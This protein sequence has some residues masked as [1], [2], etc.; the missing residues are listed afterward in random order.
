MEKDFVITDE[1][2]NDIK[3]SY[4]KHLSKII[5]DE[6]LIYDKHL[7]ISEFSYSHIVNSANDE[8]NFSKEEMKEVVKCSKDILKNKYGIIIINDNPIT[9]EKTTFS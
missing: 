9:I 4:M 5:V 3:S 6:F 1:F 7:N 2:D 8:I